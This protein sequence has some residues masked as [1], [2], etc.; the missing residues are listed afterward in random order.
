LS[1]FA[2]EWSNLTVIEDSGS[3]A[4]SMGSGSAISISGVTENPNDVVFNLAGFAQKAA[5]SPPSGNFL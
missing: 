4:F 5:T 2:E 1:V 3:R